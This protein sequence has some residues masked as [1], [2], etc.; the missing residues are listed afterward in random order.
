MPSKDTQFTPDNQPVKRRGKS[1]KTLILEAIR[2]K[3]LLECD[4][5]TEKDDVE[6]RVFGFMA[7]AAFRP[8]E[9]NSM[10]SNTCLSTLMKKGWPDMK[11]ESARA[12]FELKAEDPY[13][14]GV[15]ILKAVSE[16]KLTVEQGAS[17][18]TAVGSLLKVKETQEFDERLA[19]LEK[20]TSEQD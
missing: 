2:E 11:A 6:R 8:T 14:Q 12:E 5:D 15:E 3:A 4:S 1:P 13:G 17:L 19:A 7:E 9:E 18:I 16:G 10:V 20:A